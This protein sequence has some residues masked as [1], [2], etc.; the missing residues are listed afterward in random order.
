LQHTPQLLDRHVAWQ[1]RTFRQWLDAQ[2]AL[3]DRSAQIG[4]KAQPGL[5]ATQ[6]IVDGDA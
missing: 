2:E 5:Q 6:F 1:S 4:Q 3:T